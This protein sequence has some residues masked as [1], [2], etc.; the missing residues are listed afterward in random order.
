VSLPLSPPVEPQLALPRRRLPDGPGWAFEPKLD[1]FRAIAFVE[2]DSVH[3]QSRGGRPLGRYF[4]EVAFPPGRYV[5]DGE[6][7]IARGAGQDFEA[8][9]ARIHPA[10]SRIQRLAAE[11]PAAYRAFDLL[12]LDDDALLERPFA[13]RRA[14]LEARLGDG[15]ALLDQVLEAGE[16]EPWL[17][18]G[19]GVIAKELAAPYLP[20][21]R[22]GMVKVR[23][24]RTIDCV[25]AGYRP[26]KAE[27]TVGALILGLYEP[28]GE[29]RVV[30]H[31]SGFTAAAKRDLLALVRPLETGER[32]SAEAS[33]W[34]AGR[35]LEWVSL[36]PE[37]VAEVAFD[38]QSGGRIRHG[39]RLLRWRDDRDPASCLVDQMES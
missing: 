39:A 17:A 7:V 1:G 4:P 3:L 2:G 24:E 18:D 31:A 12:A 27:G 10:A 26:G 11:T 15:L 23:R 20:G 28:S 36:R 8:L 19:E 32:G 34:T 35:E 25:V 37:L 33:R 30:G 6:I 5:V 16:A 13:D 21:R 29:L 14:L 22:A 9:Q 38:H